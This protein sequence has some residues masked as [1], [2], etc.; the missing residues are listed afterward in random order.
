MAYLGSARTNVQVDIGFGDV[1]TPNAKEIIYPTLLDFPQPR[2]RAYPRETVVAEKLQAMVALGI[3]N[4]RM[5]DFYD[6]EV[7][8]THFSF[9]GAPLAKAI[10][11]TFDRRRTAIPTETPIVLSDEFA[12]N[13]D[14]N[15]QW[16]AFVKR[17]R[18]DDVRVGLSQVVDELHTF[19]T[20]PLFAAAKGEASDQEWIEG[21]PWESQ[22]G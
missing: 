5:R 4:S 14:K 8:A 9:D 7:I 21:G 10:K 3:V 18:L 22:K 17:N 15:V 6:V 20:P 2:I 11:A 19:L 13:R 12:G 16:Q 1:V